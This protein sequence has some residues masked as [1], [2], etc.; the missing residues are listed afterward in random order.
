LVYPLFARNLVNGLYLSS[1]Y[2]DIIE[3]RMREWADIATRVAVDVNEQVPS[4]RCDLAS[5]FVADISCWCS[6]TACQYVSFNLV[7]K[8]PVFPDVPSTFSV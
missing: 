8:N 5:F 3:L 4:G 2:H 1:G 6:F 7:A